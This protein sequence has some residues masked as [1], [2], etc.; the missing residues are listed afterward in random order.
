MAT[1][2]KTPV[3]IGR[4]PA[5]T[6]WKLI[7]VV[8]A[9]GAAV[10]GSF[11]AAGFVVLGAGEWSWVAGFLIT[12]LLLGG[13]IALSVHIAYGTITW[14]PEQ[15]LA[16]LRGRTVAIDTITEAWRTVST[17]NGA[18]YVIY[19]FV[20]TDGPSVRVLVAGRPMKGLDTAG[21]EN[22]ARFVRELPLVVPDAAADPIGDPTA[23][24][25]GA[26]TPALT[27]RQRA[28]AVSLTT[29]GGKS[30]V[31][32]ETLLTELGAAVD[33]TAE[34]SPDPAAPGYQSATHSNAGRA[35]ISA[36]EA[37]RLAARWDADDDHAARMLLAEPRPARTVRRVFFW[38]LVA[39]IAAAVLVLILAIV[40]EEVGGDLLGSGDDEL[41]GLLIVG[42]MLGAVVAY[43]AWCA[44]ADADV[45]QRRR[46][47]ERWLEERAAD[48]GDSAAAGPGS[49]RERGLA[50]PLLAAWGEPSRRLFTAGAFAVCLIGLFMAIGS[51]FFFTDDAPVAGVAVL[52][53]GVGLVVV[54]VLMFLRVQRR[55]RADAEQLVVLGGWRLLPPE[56]GD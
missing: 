9:I 10:L 4:S 14:H 8:S 50:F 43:L 52:V 37:D 28:A 48:R 32:R 3:R 17:G 51:V 20:S 2:S 1:P 5:V 22:L 23:G 12:W 39:V 49:V 45:R 29:G 56:V 13:G 33:P 46:L 7:A 24:R 19:R 53:A 38:V 35:S 36:G 15:R 31:G 16:S 30:R 11:A 40:Q 26:D 27:D 55:R 34:G 18:A 54:S 25:G 47:G 44:A 42:G 21:L 41:I 6:S